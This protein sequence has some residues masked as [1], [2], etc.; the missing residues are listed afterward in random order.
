M[1]AVAESIETLRACVRAA[2]DWLAVGIDARPDRLRDYPWRGPARSLE[3][4]AS[5]FAAEGVARLVVSHWTPDD[6]PRLAAL[7]PEHGF[8]I[9]LAGGATEMSGV[10]AA[11]DA[12]VAALILGEALFTGTVDYAAALSS[13][14]T[15]TAGVA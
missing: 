5:T 13:L 11:R 8:E 2:G 7:G 6:L 9:Q 14:G 1:W 10:L 3:E 15:M 12:G 4:L